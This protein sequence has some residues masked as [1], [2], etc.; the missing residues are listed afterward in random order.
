MSIILRVI[1]FGG[2]TS[3]TV[4]TLYIEGQEISQ[5]MNRIVD[6]WQSATG[7]RVKDR[8]VGQVLAPLP[9]QPLRIPATQP[10]TAP[11]LVAASGTGGRS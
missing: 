9:A 5:T 3:A 6:L 10:V 11:R 2:I 4:G 1:E 7:E 8:P